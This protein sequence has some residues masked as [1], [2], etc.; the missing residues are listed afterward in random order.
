MSEWIEEALKPHHDTTAFDSGNDD[1]DLYLRRFALRNH[2][3]NISKT[4]VACLSSAPITVVG[5]YTVVP[6]QLSVEDL[7][8]RM[9]AGLPRYPAGGFRLARLGVTRSL[10]RRGLG[11]DLVVAAGLRALAIAREVGGVFLVVDAMSDSLAG[12]YQRSLGME[13]LPDAPRTLVVNLQTFR[14]ADDVSAP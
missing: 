10:Q 8:A 11:Q 2:R 13:A 6:A 1:I 12:W 7:P 5:Y 4:Y 14:R 3:R 9:Q